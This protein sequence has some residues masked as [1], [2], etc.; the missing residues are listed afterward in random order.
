[1]LEYL[2]MTPLGLYRAIQHECQGRYDTLK[3]DEVSMT[4]HVIILTRANKM[5]ISI[6]CRNP[7]TDLIKY[8]HA[9]ATIQHIK[10][11]YEEREVVWWL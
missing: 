10:D 11:E 1:M 4:K 2:D 7:H 9:M 6:V 8:E 5:D 3:Y